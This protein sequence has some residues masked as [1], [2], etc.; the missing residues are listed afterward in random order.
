MG[1][2]LFLL[3]ISY[4]SKSLYNQHVCIRLKTGRYAKSLENPC[5]TASVY[6]Y[7]FLSEVIILPTYIISI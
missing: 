1:I 4:Y 2:L 6:F 5:Q 3:I 7:F